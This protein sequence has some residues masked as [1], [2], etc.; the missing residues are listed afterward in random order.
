MRE[1]LKIFH[2]ELILCTDTCSFQ[3]AAFFADTSQL[4]PLWMENIRQQVIVVLEASL[5]VWAFTS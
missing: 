1:F 2:L 4:Q 3:I 5:F